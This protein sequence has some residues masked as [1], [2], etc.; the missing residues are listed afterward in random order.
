MRMKTG[1]LTTAAIAALASLANAQQRPPIRQLGPVVAKSADALASVSGMRAL[2]GGQ[3]L[4]NDIRGRRLVL[5]DAG[6]ATKAVVADSMGTTSTTYARTGGL[7]PFR[8]DSSIFVDPSSM[9]M[10]IVDAS[11]KVARVMS[12][13]RT[14]DA[15]MLAGPLSTSV[16]F[17]ARGRLIY[18]GSPFGRGFGGFGGG[19][20]TPGF[21]PP[22]PPDS[23]PI[24]RVDLAT[25]Q[26]DTIAFGRVP[27]VRMEVTQESD[28]RIRIQ[29][30]MNPLPTVDDFAVLSDGTLAMVRGSDYHVDYYAPDGT[31]KSAP[32]IAFDWQRL[33]DE[34]KVAFLDSLKAARARQLAENPS[35]GGG[36]AL[37]GGGG[38]QI[39]I[40]GGGGGPVTVGGGA[41]GAGGANRASTA[42][43]ALGGAFQMNFVSPS[44][45]PDYK[46]AFFAGSTKADNEGNL[47]IR[48]IPTKKVEGGP[49]YDVI[50]KDGV[51]VDRVQVPA[52]TTI[53]G[54]G[55]DG[56]V[57]LTLQSNNTFYLEKAKV[58]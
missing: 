26:V 6:L 27:K 13:P 5:L 56:S 32:K 47:W 53:A 34:D 41:G 44:E 4:V 11:G 16:G 57:Y 58:R 1:I 28:G 9:S 30:Q 38:P 48:T 29:S 52:N 8:G 14:Q 19:P 22:Q 43:S 45:L 42:G 21:T 12:V 25:R 3:V 10:L 18:R 15:M 55:S 50:N 35:G 7:I 37:G 33:T 54:F 17:D 40:V 2:G 39:Q 24:L 36:A 20:G 31:K 49:V 46:P 23:L 51:L